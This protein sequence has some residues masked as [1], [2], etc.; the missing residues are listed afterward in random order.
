MDFLH[1]S[2]QR[3]WTQAVTEVSRGSKAGG[4]SN[5]CSS[6]FPFLFPIVVSSCYPLAIV[7]LS[8]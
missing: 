6:L 2:S 5:E 8:T 4:R 3:G 7:H 1:G